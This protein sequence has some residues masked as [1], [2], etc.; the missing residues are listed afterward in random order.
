MHVATAPRI[1]PT[2]GTYAISHSA[3]HYPVWRVC[4]LRV[5]ACGRGSALRVGA[6]GRRSG[7]LAPT[8][9]APRILYAAI[10]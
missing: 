4:A 9:D 6:C 7:L 1:R 5:G 3:P 10:K 2:Y 8:P